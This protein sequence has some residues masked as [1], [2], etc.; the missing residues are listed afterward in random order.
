MSS[1]YCSSRLN[2]VKIS[3]QNMADNT[4]NKVPNFQKKQ[5]RFFRK[6]SE[7]SVQKEKKKETPSLTFLKEKV[8][9]YWNTRQIKKDSDIYLS[10][11]HLDDFNRHKSKHI[12]DVLPETIAFLRFIHDTTPSDTMILFVARDCY[13][14]H[15]LYKKMYPNDTNFCYLYCSRKV[16]YHC[17]NFR[18]YLKSKTDGY[19][20]VLWI[21]IQGSG[22]SH[23]IFYENE[24]YIPRKLFLKKN[25][26]VWNDYRNK[27]ITEFLPEDWKVNPGNRYDGLNFAYYLESL[28]LAP[29]N[30]I[31]ELDSDY[32]PIFSP[33][34][35]FESTNRND[36]IN[37][38]N[39]IERYFFV[40]GIN[41]RTRP[42]QFMS[43]RDDKDFKGLV[44]FDIDNTI[45]HKNNP[46]AREI[47]DFCKENNIK[48]IL[49]T[50]RD[51]VFYDSQHQT[52]LKDILE[53]N[54]LFSLPYKIDV[55]FNPFQK[56]SSV[57]RISKQKF[58]Q[59][60][61]ATREL[62]ISTNKVFVFDDQYSNLEYLER[63][64]FPNLYHV[65]GN[66]G[67]SKEQFNLFKETFMS[68]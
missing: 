3:L 63:N 47:V 16:M 13:F 38:Y 1:I 34:G 41:I 45:S 14:L 40:D 58:L 49:C 50:A 9:V 48:I 10:E 12:W 57:I 59:I 64:N 21:D 42:Y 11:M 35:D 26:L 28:F 62:N 7:R 19:K 27:F 22:S 5:Y 55:W 66:V 37:E 56:L 36:L 18:N 32:N 17:P 33:F 4:K 29:Y 51:Q 6:R 68:I 25:H 24:D 54:N 44:V 20:D 67:I 43:T 30:T 8:D 53:Y 2:F 60:D 52:F 46:F 23:L 65:N 61:F 39:I 31:T 15:L